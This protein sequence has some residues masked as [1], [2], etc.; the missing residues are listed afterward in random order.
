MSPDLFE[1]CP[2]VVGVADDHGLQFV[3]LEQIQHLSSAHLVKAGVEALKQSGHRC[4]EHVVDVG[5]DKL[6]PGRGGG[7][8]PK[9]TR[10]FTVTLLFTCNK[11]LSTN[12]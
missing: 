3:R 5:A 7:G 9:N 12:L 10:C 4:V 6:L 8:P 11:L 1:L 2:V